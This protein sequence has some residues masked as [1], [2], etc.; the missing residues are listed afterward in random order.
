MIRPLPL[1]K[2]FE[3]RFAALAPTV[4]APAAEEAPA[5][6]AAE[7]APAVE[8]ADEDAPTQ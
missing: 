4:E 8:A 7:D 1:L 6:P 5:A 2:R 3:E